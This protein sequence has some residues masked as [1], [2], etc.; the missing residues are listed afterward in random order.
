[1]LIYTLYTTATGFSC[2][3]IV[4][5]QD[6]SVGAAHSQFP[7]LVEVEDAFFEVVHLAQDQ[8]FV[9]HSVVAPQQRQCCP[10]Q[11]LFPLKNVENAQLK[12]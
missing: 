2:S 12:A 4:T 7:L 10:L 6:T 8:G 3:L 5:V 9:K 11:H 1:M